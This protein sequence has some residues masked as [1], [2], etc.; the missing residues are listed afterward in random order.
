MKGIFVT[1][2]DTGIGKTVISAA[3]LSVFRKREKVCYWKPI[4][5]GIEEDNDTETIRTLV[6]CTDEEIY[7]KGIRLEKPLS[8]HLSARLADEEISIEG[9]LSFIQNRGEDKF[10]IV[11]GAGGVL[12]PLNESELMIDFMDALNLP[13]LV[14]ARSGLGTINHTLL[15]IKALRN[16]NL[17]ILGVIMNGKPNLENKKAIEHFGSVPVLAEMP[18]FEKIDSDRLENWSRQ[19]DLWL[20]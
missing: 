4:Q 14:A 12:V 11:E 16:H 20:L 6:K 8:P 18:E 10:W 9:V 3:L 5:T 15:T 2:T 1:G 19:V 17:E 13:V 7:D